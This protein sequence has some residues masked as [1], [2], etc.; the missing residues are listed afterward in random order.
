MDGGGAQAY[1][2]DSHLQMISMDLINVIKSYSKEAVWVT[3]RE[4]AISISIKFS[5]RGHQLGVPIHDAHGGS[6][7]I[8]QV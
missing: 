6:N 7:W 4:S 5:I 8:Y 3:E 2:L 1:T